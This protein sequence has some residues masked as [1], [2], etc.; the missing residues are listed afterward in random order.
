MLTLATSD[1]SVEGYHDVSLTI[2]LAEF[3]G[4]PVVTKLFQLH[5]ECEIIEAD[6]LII[7]QLLNQRIL[8]D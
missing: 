8:I 1:P 5:I 6:A 2:S 4:I 3:P 7:P